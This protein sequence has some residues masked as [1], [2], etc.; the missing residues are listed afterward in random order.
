MLIE[1]G[2]TPTDAEVKEMMTAMGATD[3]VEFTKV[4]LALLHLLIEKFLDIMDKK[5]HIPMSQDPLLDAF[6][7]LD[8]NKTGMTTSTK[9]INWIRKG[10][11]W[12]ITI[13]PDRQQ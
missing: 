6:L 10:W 9:M 7:E 1:L 12:R 13:H 11:S 2:D 4:Y 8:P 3:F 5:L